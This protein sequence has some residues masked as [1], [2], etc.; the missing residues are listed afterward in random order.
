MNLV[1]FIHLEAVTIHLIELFGLHILPQ[2][3]LPNAVWN[4]SK[5]I[6]SMYTRWDCKDLV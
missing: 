4:L 3:P 5:A 6:R 2:K 1:F